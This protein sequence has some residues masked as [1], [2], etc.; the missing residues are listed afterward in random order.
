MSKNNLK[1]QSKNGGI[2]DLSD[3]AIDK[4][5]PKGYKHTLYVLELS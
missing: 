1:L 2:V 3:E 5:G 4:A